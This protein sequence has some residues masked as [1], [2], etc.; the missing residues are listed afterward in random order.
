MEEEVRIAALTLEAL[1][2]E[3]HGLCTPKTIVPWTHREPDPVVRQQT[4]AENAA[5]V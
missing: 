5:P 2:V 4:L 3:L 1:R